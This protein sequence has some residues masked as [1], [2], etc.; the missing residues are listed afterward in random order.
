MDINVLR[1]IVAVV[2][3]ALFIGIVLWAWSGQQRERFEE[4]SRLPFAEHDE[5]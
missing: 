2:C 1:G 3:L 4:A 5:P